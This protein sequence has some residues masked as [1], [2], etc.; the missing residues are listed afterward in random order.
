M[1]QGKASTGA[2]NVLTPW[3]AM[4]IVSWFSTS[5]LSC[6]LFTFPC[7]L[8][9][10]VSQSMESN[11]QEQISV[12]LLLCTVCSRFN[13]ALNGHKLPVRCVLLSHLI[14][15]TVELREGVT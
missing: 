11:Q 15:E 12:L 9:L 6:L 8:Y 2:E 4:D 1:V 7:Y 3:P 13:G 10:L 14:D 5:F